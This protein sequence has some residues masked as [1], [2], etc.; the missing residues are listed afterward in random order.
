M[1]IQSTRYITREKAEEKW[2]E[3][4]LKERRD[5]YIKYATLL[6]DEEI[7]DAIEETF[8]DYQ[9]VSIGEEDGV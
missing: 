3:K 9:I 8:D 6:S 7:E 5:V 4:K 2:V 1:G